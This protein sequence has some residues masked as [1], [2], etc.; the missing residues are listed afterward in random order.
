MRTSEECYYTI[1]RKVQKMET[2]IFIE[3][4]SIDPPREK[5]YQRLGYRKKTTAISA[6][7]FKETELFINEA[8]AFISLQGIFSRLKI[9]HNDGKKYFYPEM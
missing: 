6:N 9:N 7:Q 8:T 4:I 5:I 3:K 2:V 1:L